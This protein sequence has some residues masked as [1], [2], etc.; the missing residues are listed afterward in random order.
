M[1]NTA[2]PSS[3]HAS[4]LLHR[5]EQP[6]MITSART[7]SSSEITSRMRQYTL[8]MAFRM[9]C[10]VGMVLIDGWL[11][12]ALLA[13]AVFMPYLAVVIANQADQ[14]TGPGF[15]TASPE[16]LV[17]IT[18]GS[19]EDPLDLGSSVVLEGTVVD[20]LDET[21]RVRAA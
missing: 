16:P 6:V 12:W 19:L 14:R 3:D 7:A 15:E 21:E 9:A 1:N 10:F 17:A 13:V 18:A 11:R 20:D 5:P 4:H 8:A 2:S